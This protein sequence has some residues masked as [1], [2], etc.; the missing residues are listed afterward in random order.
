MNENILDREATTA[1]EKFF[2]DKYCRHESEL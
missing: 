2:G 1:I